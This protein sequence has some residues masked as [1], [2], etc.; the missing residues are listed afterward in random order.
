MTF[1]AAV[2]AGLVTGRLGAIG[3]DV[4]SPEERREEEDVSLRVWRRFVT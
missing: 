1:L 2:V 4:A 3:R